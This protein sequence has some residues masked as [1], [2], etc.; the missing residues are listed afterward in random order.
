MTAMQRKTYADAVLD[1]IDS[2]DNDFQSITGQVDN[3]L[4]E[5]DDPSK[6]DYEAREKAYIYAKQYADTKLELENIEGYKLKYNTY[7]FEISLLNAS[8]INYGA[9]LYGN[10]YRTIKDVPGI[11]NNWFKRYGEYGWSNGDL[12]NRN[13]TFKTEK[14]YPEGNLLTT[15]GGDDSFA[16][17]LRPWIYYEKEKDTGILHDLEWYRNS[18]NIIGQNLLRINN[19]KLILFVL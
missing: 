1:L 10:P 16:P 19:I 8:N 12:G 17:N 11:Y 7:G 5:L 15:G 9:Y 3:S 14:C 4:K 2:L 6:D 13:K 18:Y